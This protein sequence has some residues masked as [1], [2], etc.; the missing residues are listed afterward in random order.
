MFAAL[1]VK[2]PLISISLCVFFILLY[3]YVVMQFLPMQNVQTEK[4]DYIL[5]QD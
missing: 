4:K 1:I 5:L 3:I 2:V